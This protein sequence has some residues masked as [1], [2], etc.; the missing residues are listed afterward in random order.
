MS[1][2]LPAA[3][4]VASGPSPVRRSRLCERGDAPF[5][6]RRDQRVQSSDVGPDGRDGQTEC[7][8]RVGV[9]LLILCV[10]FVLPVRPFIFVGVFCPVR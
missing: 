4:T 5:P 9:M 8:A 1:Q 10:L 6:P 2:C 7:R 3:M